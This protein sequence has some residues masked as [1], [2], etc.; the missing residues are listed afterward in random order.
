MKKY[1]KQQKN[2]MSL[3]QR[4]QHNNP[5][6]A[7]LQVSEGS[8][9]TKYYVSRYFLSH[10]YWHDTHG[11]PKSTRDLVILFPWSEMCRAVCLPWHVADRLSA[12]RRPLNVLIYP[13]FRPISQC[14]HG[15]PSR[16]WQ[17]FS[18]NPFTKATCAWLY[19]M[20]ISTCSWIHKWKENISTTSSWMCVVYS[21]FGLT[22]T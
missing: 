12:Q 20:Q 13:A 5:S 15:L 19:V 18:R 14:F 6:K 21:A 3:K 17:I 1:S 2:T 9:E 16:S 8:W 10:I 22:L 7:S 11:W 4:S